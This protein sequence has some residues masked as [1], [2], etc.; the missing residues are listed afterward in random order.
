MTWR[1]VFSSVACMNAA[2][3]ILVLS[4][5]PNTRLIGYFTTRDWLPLCR[6]PFMPLPRLIRLYSFPRNWFN[7]IRFSANASLSTCVHW[8]GRRYLSLGRV[9]ESLNRPG[10]IDT[11]AAYH[12]RRDISGIPLFFYFLFSLIARESPPVES[13][14][15]G[16]MARLTPEKPLPTG[17]VTRNQIYNSSPTGDHHRECGLYSRIK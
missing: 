5:W 12:E 9:I 13:E 10:E 17:Y 6:S 16:S 3:L 1:S 2:W 14:I 7:C 15:Y 4:T 11:W 8:S